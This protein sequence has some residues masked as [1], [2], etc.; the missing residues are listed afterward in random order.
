MSAKPAA[1]VLR[2]SVLEH[3][4]KAALGAAVLIVLSALAATRWVPYAPE[5]AGILKRVA[6]ARAAVN[7]GEWPRSEQQRFEAGADDQP[8]NLVDRRLFA[9][10]SV[11]PHY[12]S[13]GRLSRRPGEELRLKEAVLVA[14]EDPI[15]SAG[16][17]FLR[18]RL[19]GAAEFSVEEGAADPR[20]AAPEDA[21]LP[22]DLRPRRSPGA[23]WTPSVEEP[24]GTERH[25][26]SV[27]FLETAPAGRGYSFAAFRAVFPIGDQVRRV[28]DAIHRPAAVARRLTEV[29]DFEVQRQQ[30]QREDWTDWRPVDPQVFLDVA[31][32]AG[33]LDADVVPASVTDSAMTCPL[34]ERLLGI[35]GAHAS[36]P[37]L[38]AFELGEAEL[39]RE[40]QYL[41]A[42]VNVAADRAATTRREA[43]R[44]GFNELLRDARRLE[45]LLLDGA[46][47]PAGIGSRGAATSRGR[48]GHVAAG[49]EATLD[50]LVADLAREMD[51]SA[52]DEKLKDWI[53]RRA[54]AAGE[55]LLFRYLDFDVEPGCTYRYRVRLVLR[56]PNY[57]RPLAEADGAHVV[58]G[59]TRMTPWCE[60]SAPVAVPGTVKYFLTRVEP[61]RLRTL[62]EARLNFFQWDRGLGTTV[63]Q[64]LD[65]PVGRPVGGTAPATTI[66]AVRA[67]FM[68]ADYAFAARDTLVDLLPDIG[69]AAAD[70]PDLQLPRGSRG[71][72]RVVE[73]AAVV[74]S[75][76]DLATLDPLTSVD[77]LLRAVHYKEQ[78]D[79]VFEERRQTHRLDDGAEWGHPAPG[80]GTVMQPPR[81]NP[82][83]R[84]GR[85]TPTSTR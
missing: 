82:L 7:T 78:Q 63:Q 50:A 27:D 10:Y 1:A 74:T 40:L 83:G 80:P 47:R 2:R 34:P 45:T 23:P 66:D 62:P 16:Q 44:G 51:P 81:S 15:A 24:S 5:P 30:R 17:A 41:R 68:Q 12:E 20:A 22:D 57:G 54:T 56:N 61:N 25:L 79:R 9:R 69:L 21:D 37:R 31:R 33:G 36:H 29:L 55:L 70:H 26:G 6:A 60:P 11:W 58:A 43:R 76:G 3:G 71:L 64:E 14:V 75:D 49:G 84:G 32:S 53:R 65:V 52:R 39:E 73:Q 48:R 67:T 18:H 42:L 85:K 28:V 46:S 77:E 8:R 35:W 4:E 59:P 19:V 38:K 72:A 13:S